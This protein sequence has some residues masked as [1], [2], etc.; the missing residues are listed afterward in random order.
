MRI[1]DSS[2]Y[3]GKY[4]RTLRKSAITA[5]LESDPDTKELPSGMRESFAKT[6]GQRVLA[7]ALAGRISRCIN[8]RKWS[9]RDRTSGHSAILRIIAAIVDGDQ[10]DRNYVFAAF[11]DT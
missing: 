6:G 3:E 5:R 9:R 1:V 2:F 4:V 11:L 8:D 10:E 7:T